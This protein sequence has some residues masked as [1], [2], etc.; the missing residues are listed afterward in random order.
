MVCKNKS[1]NVVR[2]ALYIVEKWKKTYL[3]EKVMEKTLWIQ[4]IVILVI[5]INHQ[6]QTVIDGPV[7]YH[8][9]NIV[10]TLWCNSTTREIHFT[11]ENQFWQELHRDH[12]WSLFSGEYYNIV[13]FILLT[14]HSSRDHSSNQKASACICLSVF[15]GISSSGVSYI[16]KRK[17]ISERKISCLSEK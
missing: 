10:I 9:G 8:H 4:D 3:H 12:S 11:V 14:V 5:K 2:H 17:H 6:S 15:F 1:K 7:I 16:M 13:W